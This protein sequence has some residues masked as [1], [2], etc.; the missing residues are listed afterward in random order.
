[1][2]QRNVVNSQTPSQV[3]A[4]T[5]ARIEA[6]AHHALIQAWSTKTKVR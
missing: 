5:P 1:M 6:R 3:T 4:N 2:G